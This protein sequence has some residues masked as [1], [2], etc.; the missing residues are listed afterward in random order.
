[1]WVGSFFESLLTLGIEP[2]AVPAHRLKLLFREWFAAFNGVSLS[3]QQFAKK[4]PNL[5]NFLILKII[6]RASTDPNEL[7]FEHM[8]EV[9]SQ[10]RNKTCSEKREWLFSLLCNADENQIKMHDFIRM[11]DSICGALRSIYGYGPR[12]ISSE[13]VET[14][15]HHGTYLTLGIFEELAL[16]GFKEMESLYLLVD[17]VFCDLVGPMQFLPQQDPVAKEG[18]LHFSS[19]GSSKKSKFERQWCRLL[20]NGTFVCMRRGVAIRVELM[21]AWEGFGLR[22]TPFS[23]FFKDG[24][25]EVELYL[26]TGWDNEL[27]FVCESEEEGKAWLAA[28]QTMQATHPI[29]SQR[30]E[31]EK[32]KDREKEKEDDTSDSI[33]MFPIQSDCV[34]RW[35]VD[36]HDFFATAAKA[37]QSAQ[38]TI[39]ITDWMISPKLYLIRMGLLPQHQLGSMLKERAVA[40]VRIYIL[41]YS[42]TLATREIG[43]KKAERFLRELDDNIW[44]VRHPRVTLKDGKLLYSHH[45]KLLVIDETLAFVGGL[46]LCFGRYDTPDHPLTDTDFAPVYPG[47]DYK[48]PCPQRKRKKKNKNKNK[49]KIKTQ[50]HRG[51]H[52]GPMHGAESSTSQTVESGS[53]E[54]EDEEEEEEEGSSS[55]ASSSVQEESEGDDDASSH[56]GEAGEET[57]TK[58]GLHFPTPMEIHQDVKRKIKAFTP[59]LPKLKQKLKQ[60]PFSK[61]VRAAD[62]TEDGFHRSGVDRRRTVRLPWHD[63]HSMVT[64]KAAQD[65]ALSFIQRWN[66]HTMS[67]EGTYPLIPCN[68]PQPLNEIQAN[69]SVGGQH[70]NV[71]VIRSMSKWSGNSFHEKSIEETYVKLIEESLHY[72]YIENQF[73][74]SNTPTNED[75]KN[76]IAS[77]L[78]ARVIRAAKNGETFRVYIVMPVNPDLG[79]DDKNGRAVMHYQYATISRGGKSMMEQ[80]REALFQYKVFPSDYISFTSLRTHAVLNEFP[81]TGQIYVHSK[82][83][84]VDDRHCIIGSANINDRSL[85]GDRDSEIALWISDSCMSV[86]TPMNGVETST[87]E[88]AKSLRLALWSEH[89]G[90]D[91]EKIEDRQA[92]QD[93]MADAFYKNIWQTTAFDNTRAYDFV[94]PETPSDSL[95]TLAM[96][97][98]ASSMPHNHA[99]ILTRVRGHLVH[100]PQQFLADEDMKTSYTD[101]SFYVSKNLFT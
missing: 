65:V 72:I 26:S 59:K 66:H 67:A 15:S 81:V 92:L 52:T 40:G 7:R 74:I 98:G 11:L 5:N 25:Q 27:S 28:L 84:I 51:W 22:P 95:K 50:K 12:R 100:F 23:P 4:F 45:Q 80:L 39:F 37:I 58:R 73:F 38:R 17:V 87:G 55:S 91:L 53:A 96:V 57:D 2:G 42:E 82:L 94:F 48:N 32:E 16:H 36:G 29:R 79:F 18:F 24:E 64:G 62:G 93:P 78:V 90:Y 19:K 44:V 89:L 69:L 86:T 97:F 30:S 63:V 13:F 43:S 34:T 83:M 41:L 75:A 68:E 99:E 6:F 47:K 21:R 77:S 14:C 1:M 9:G 71:Q 20:S 76:R 35:F 8:V 56:E 33:A 3:R 49:N 88:F 46:D 31:K 85:L 54:D 61:E 10:I 101:P 70:C 60:N